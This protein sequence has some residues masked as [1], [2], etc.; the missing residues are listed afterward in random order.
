MY[1]LLTP[2]SLS[3]TLSLLLSDVL[4]EICGVAIYLLRVWLDGSRFIALYDICQH[5]KQSNQFARYANCI[6]G[7]GK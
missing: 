3:F 1:A 2:I 4:R 6:R 7:K 5:Y